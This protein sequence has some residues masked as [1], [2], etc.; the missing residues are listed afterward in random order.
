MPGVGVKAT[1]DRG[2]DVMVIMLGMNDILAPYVSGEP[3]EIE[4][5]T[6]TLPDTDPHLRQRVHP[7]VVALCTIT[8]ATEDSRR[9]KTASSSS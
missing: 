3:K 6:S 9:R 2:A 4:A 8:L 7:R 1:L 5:W